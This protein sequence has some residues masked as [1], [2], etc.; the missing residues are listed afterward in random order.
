MRKP[1]SPWAALRRWN[2]RMSNEPDLLRRGVHRY[3][4]RRTALW[5]LWK[6]LSLGNGLHRRWMLAERQL[7]GRRASGSARGKSQL[8]SKIFRI[9]AGCNRLAEILNNV[10]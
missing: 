10:A 5:C 9:P 8:A 1:L 4:H 7:W 3:E 6:G 2:V